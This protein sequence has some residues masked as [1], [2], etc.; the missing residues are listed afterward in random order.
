MQKL[1]KLKKKADKLWTQK[2][3]KD[4]CEVCGGFAVE[5]H[6]FFPK[7]GYDILRH[8]LDNGVSICRSCHFKHHTKGDPKI[9]ATIMEQR[10]EEWYRKLLELT[11]C[12]KKRGIKDIRKVIEDLTIN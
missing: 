3:L 9:H 1:T 4:Y 11:R 7:G 10:G 6:H 8:N 5:V 12:K 2:L